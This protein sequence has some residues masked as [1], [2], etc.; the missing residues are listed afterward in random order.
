MNDAAEAKE[1]AAEG[2]D[3]DAKWRETLPSRLQPVAATHGKGLF[4]FTLCICQVN[5]DISA[6]AGLIKAHDARGR[7]IRVAQS[8]NTITEIGRIGNGWTGEDIIRCKT[9]IDAALRE[10]I[11]PV[12]S[13]IIVPSGTRH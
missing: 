1:I 9:D 8:L 7:L 2:T 5:E 10:T 13:A 3:T 11:I 12:G 6:M 4:S